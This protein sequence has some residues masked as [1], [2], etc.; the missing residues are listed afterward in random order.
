MTI[1]HCFKCDCD[2]PI[3]DFYKHPKMADGHLNKC[4]EC[5]KYDVHKNR[6]ANSDYYK[7][8]D[9][10]RANLPH[11]VASRQAY[12][13]TPAFAKSHEAASKQWKDKNPDRKNASDIV[14]RAIRD[15][16]LKKQ[17]CF[18][19]GSVV[20]HGHH[21]DYSRPLDVVWLCPKHHKEAH[22]VEL[23]A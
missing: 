1:K 17:P 21:P 20:V 8:F 16:K 12:A 7:A 11:R 23:R 3:D 9:K 22:S 5:A 10:S 6:D 13:K 18:T 4:K 14:N 15:G 19:C 2:K